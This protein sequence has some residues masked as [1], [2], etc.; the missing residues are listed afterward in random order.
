MLKETKVLEK[1][2]KFYIVMLQNVL[3][4]LVWRISIVEKG[5]I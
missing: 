4:Q 3:I 5:T 2:Q 1:I